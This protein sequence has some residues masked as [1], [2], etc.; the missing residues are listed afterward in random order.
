MIDLF[1]VYCGA[2]ID[3]GTGISVPMEMVG[4]VAKIVTIRKGL[5]KVPIQS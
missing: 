1:F 2:I 4:I 5:D 3:I